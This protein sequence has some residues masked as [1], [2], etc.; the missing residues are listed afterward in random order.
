[1]KRL[2]YIII[3]AAGLSASLAA[4]DGKT[5][6]IPAPDQITGISG[7]AIND[8]AVS[9]PR[10]WIGTNAL[11]M[12][13]DNGMSWHIYS[14]EDGIG[15]GSVSAIA[16]KGDTLWVATAFDTTTSLG[17]YDAGGGLSYSLDGGDTWTWV[18]QPVDS[19]DVTG[20]SP[21]TTV[22]NNLTYDI[23]L[24]DSTVWIAS[25]AGGLRKSGDMGKTWQVVT[26]DGNPFSAVS[27]YAHRLFSVM[28]DG[29]AIWAGSAGGVHK[30]LDGGK[31]WVTFSHQNQDQPVSGNFV[32]ALAHQNTSRGPVV[33]AATVEAVDMGEYRAVSYTKDGG[34][35]WDVCLNS[36]FAHNFA[37]SG[38]DVYVAT[39]SG[40]FKS[41]DLGGRWAAF[42]FIRDRDT[43]EGV[44][45]TEFYS[46]GAGPETGLW[47]GSGDGAAYSRDNGISW[48]VFRAFKSTGL[49]SQPETYAFPNPFSPYR[50]NQQD[51]D[52]HV[53]FQYN[54]SAPSAVTVKVYDYGMNL[55]RTVADEIYR[56]GAGDYAEVWNGRNEL[57]D[58]VANGVYFY[59][60]YIEGTGTVWGKVLVV[61]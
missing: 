7:N 60:V 16:R 9:G 19:Q 21:T 49:G 25:F 11:C 4:E 34:L 2:L 1:M 44:Y 31:T 53:R 32:V 51:G 8:I 18:P 15:R 42:P 45:S 59:S 38:D 54:V 3:A 22:I 20:Y 41:V 17:T 5:L 14:E 24:T 48:K 55:V 30:S 27:Y 33:W 37:F 58:V 43:G 50:H 52:G 36:T 47:A 57:G 35:S 39:S 46:V 12:T 13:E 61:D 6:F 23:A 29:S 56:P 26:V 40:L 10:I 28:Y